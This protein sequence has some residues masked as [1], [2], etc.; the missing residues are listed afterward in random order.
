MI[1]LFYNI[2]VYLGLIPGP[3]SVPSAEELIEITNNATKVREENKIKCQNENFKNLLDNMQECASG[4]ESSYF[5]KDW[6]QIG[7]HNV[8]I[9][10]EK[11]YIVNIGEGN[12]LIIKWQTM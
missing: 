12:G 3:T 7:K 2:A 10:K 6:R 8:D 11:R 9:L 1:E 4:G 5:Y